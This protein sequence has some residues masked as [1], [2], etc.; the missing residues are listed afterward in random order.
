MIGLSS[1]ILHRLSNL[2]TEGQHWLERLPH[3]LAR[4]KHDWDLELGRPLEGGSEAL[5]MEAKRGAEAV[6]LKVAMPGSTFATEYRVLH[7]AQGRGYARLLEVDA[8][9]RSMLLEK[10]GPRLSDSGL[11]VQ[12]QLKTLCRSYLAAWV[13]IKSPQGLVSGARKA[14]WLRLFIQKQ[15]LKLGKPCSED[16]IK[17]ANRYAES[18]RAAHCPEKCVLVHGDGHGNNALLSDA[19]TGEYRFVDPDGLFAE[20]A[21]DLSAPMR[22]WSEDILSSANP[23]R[24]ARERCEFL[25]SLT[26]VPEG[27][28]WEWGYLERVSTGLMCHLIGCEKEGRDMLKVAELMAEKS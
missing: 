15:W 11:C 1:E 12:E 17:L 5:V 22:G 25:A 21:Y 9:Q 27:P 7:L 23:V 24:T 28:I 20:A 2:G 26:R 4:L 18:R 19:T 16:A 6:V 14:V 3:T 8:A 13:P 10:L